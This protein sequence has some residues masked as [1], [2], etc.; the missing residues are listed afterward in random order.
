M[1][2]YQTLMYK[3][4][5]SQYVLLIHQ[6]DSKVRRV[7]LTPTGDPFVKIHGS[8]TGPTLLLKDGKCGGDAS[9]WKWKPLTWKEVEV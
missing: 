7:R 2:W 4:F 5:G 9:Y 3:L 1:S 6:F 8:T